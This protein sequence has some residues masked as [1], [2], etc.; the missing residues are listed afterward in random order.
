MLIRSGLHR[1]GFR[2]RLHDRKLP[3]RPD[4]VLPGRKAVVLVHGCFWHGHDC[5]LFRW[6]SSRE[7]FWREKIVGNMERDARSRDELFAQ[8]DFVS[9]H[10]PLTPE[11]RHSVGERELGL[12]KPSAYL[13][14]TA[15]GAV[16]DEQ[17]LIAA[18]RAGRIA[19]AGLDVMETEPLP[20]SSPLCEMPNVVLQAHIGSATVETRRAMIDLA[21]RNLLDALSGQQPQA[22]VN[23]QVWN[24]NATA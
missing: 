22:M 12:M 9:V 15:R 23:P 11:T 10:I 19:G 17:A 13:I 1:L 2:F 16:V 5:H 20:P 3:G 6:P 21:A 7:Q 8:S 14:N 18:L 24:A 4:L